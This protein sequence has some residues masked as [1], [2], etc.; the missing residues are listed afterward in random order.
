[1]WSDPEVGRGGVD[2]ERDDVE[3]DEELE[4]A[5]MER[6]IRL[7]GDYQRHHRRLILKEMKLIVIRD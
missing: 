6:V 5:V 7:K 4:G 2:S 3:A 1:M